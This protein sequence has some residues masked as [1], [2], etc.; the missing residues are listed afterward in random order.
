[1]RA[2]LR[3]WLTLRG[4]QLVP[5]RGDFDPIEVSP[6]LRYFWICRKEPETGRFRFR[7]AGEEIRHLIGKPVAGAYVEDLFPIIAHQLHE[8]LETVVSV[9]ALHH[10][11]GPL[12][13]GD[14]RWIHAERLALPA[15]Q[16]DNVTTVLAATIFSWPENKKRS[17]AQLAGDVEPTIIPVS[18]L[19]LS[20][21][22]PEAP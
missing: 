17:G 11:H 10:A 7:L 15:R 3:Y 9:P 18:E 19:T 22:A 1:M 21:V 14:S 20:D 6:I 4:D 12:Y 2:F 13:R 16:K 8:A 5:D